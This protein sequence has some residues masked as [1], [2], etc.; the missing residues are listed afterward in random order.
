M[1]ALA[2]EKEEEEEGVK[3]EEE[4]EE[5]KLLSRASLWRWATFSLWLLDTC[6]LGGDAWPADDG[7]PSYPTR[8]CLG[9]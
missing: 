2:N 6:A 3:E 5:G 9:G 7:A 1:S 8:H 4:E